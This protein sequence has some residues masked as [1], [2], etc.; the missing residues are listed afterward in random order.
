MLINSSGQVKLCDFGVSKDLQK[1][2][3]ETFVGTASYMA[4]ERLH[5]LAH[6]VASDVWSL[7]LS[8]M[9]LAMGRYPIPCPSP[10]E[11]RALFA[12]QAPRPFGKIFG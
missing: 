11:F 10:T 3:A 12:S 6:G 4:P 7:G 5:G 1:S 2:Q 9:E 8:I